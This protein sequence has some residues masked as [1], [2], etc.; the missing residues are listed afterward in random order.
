M[1][2][3]IV[4]P[5]PPRSRA[6]NRVTALRWA[7]ILENLGHRVV[8]G[9]PQSSGKA[10][11]LVAL[12]ARRSAAAVKDFHQRYPQLPIFLALT[13]TDLYQD[14]KVSLAARRAVETATLLIVL[15]DRA[16]RHL[17]PRHRGKSRVVYQSVPKTPGS[18][19][20]AARHFQ[21]SVVGH[22]RPLKDPMRTALAVRR[23]PAESRILV[24]HA[25]RSLTEALGLQARRESRQN[26]RYRWLGELPR[27]QTRRL[28]ARSRLLVLTSRL[29]GGA[30]VLSEALVDGIPVLASKIPG[31]VG[32]LGDA[33]P[34]YFRVG[35]TLGLRKLMLRAEADPG[36]HRDLRD[37]CRALAPR[38]HPRR[39]VATWKALL[40]E[41]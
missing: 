9:G 20:P 39:E 2:I 8:I 7:R 35:D 41:A 37:R 36:F 32:I 28:I 12:H 1:K 21:V 14:L 29:E 25:G 15:Q 17:P 4:C 13:G 23:L 34:G 18:P 27:W 33:Y 16:A 31:S 26:P 40:R 38:F 5:T 19:R 24:L 10:D 30:H 3:R 11:F 22:L 6:G